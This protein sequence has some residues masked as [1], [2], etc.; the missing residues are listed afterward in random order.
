VPHKE[1][2]GR[3]S[4]ERGNGIPLKTYIL[5]ENQPRQDFLIYAIIA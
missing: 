5:S 2:L 4:F 3:V 1:D